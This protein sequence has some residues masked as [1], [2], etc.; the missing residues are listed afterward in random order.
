MSRRSNPFS[1]GKL[2]LVLLVGSGAFLLFLYAIGA[3]WTGER[4]RAG[5][6]HVNSNALDG[7]SALAELLELRGYSVDV[8]R[9]RL[10]RENE[11]LLVLTPSLNTDPAELDELMELRRYIG[12]TLVILPKWYSAPLPDQVAG[13]NPS[14]WVQLGRGFTPF[15]FEQVEDFEPM[16][17]SQGKTRGWSGLGY[18]G[19]L[20]DEDFIQAITD[21][22]ERQLFPIISDSEGDLLAGYWNRNGYH[23]YLADAAGVRFSE[24]EEYGQD[25]GLY[26]L[27][28]VA[29]PDLMNN[30]GLS[31]RTRAQA[32]I[33]L[34]DATMEGYDYSIV[35]DMTLP[36]L[37]SAENLL[38]LAFRPPFLAATL[39]L[40]LVFLVIG[41]RAFRRF[42]PPVAEEQVHVLGK[43]QLARN[44]AALI[45]RARRWHLLGAPYA[46][47]IAGRIAETQNIRT[48][49]PETREAAI[50]AAL[51]RQGIAG[52][53][54]S[55]KAHAL[56]NARGPAEMI[57][58]ASALK[59]IERMLKR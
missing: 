22:P 39:C 14:D 18:S 27:V 59:A 31:D 36:G 40:L 17:L 51:A 2:V 41:W 44:G 9:D 34:I 13:E 19:D 32:A 26:P 28:I 45:E 35:F 15:W 57:R 33:S 56:R 3:G 58:A 55:E 4:E 16:Q 24:D 53:T 21:L 29:E 12:P 50:D 30:Y 20:P 10:V 48:L 54:F 49:D 38:T 5:T 11:V 43:T 52:P 7:F 23:P 42:G 6:A 25:E 46:S 37:G 47:V 1:V 8:A